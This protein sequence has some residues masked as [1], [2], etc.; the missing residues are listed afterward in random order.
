MSL[1]NPNKPVTEQR[2]SEFY[3]QILPF[4]GGM[5]DILT[6]KFSKGDLYSTDEKMIGRWIDGKPIYQK[7]FLF[8]SSVTIPSNS[9][10]NTN[11]P[12]GDIEQTLKCFCYKNDYGISF[13][14]YAELD[15]NVIELLQ[16]RGSEMGQVNGFVLQYT[17]TTDSSVEIGVDTDYSTEEKIVGT[18]IDGKPL[19]QKTIEVNITLSSDSWAGSVDVS[20]FNL[21]SIINAIGHSSALKG[22]LSIDTRVVSDT[23]SI[24]TSDLGGVVVNRLTLQYTKT[25]D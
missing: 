5:P 7:V 11:M 13:P 9:W 1:T 4:L 23:L 15:A 12:S 17:K 18:W 19:Y 21:D 3:Q 2:L 6:N 25:T 10:F 16:T 22:S 24:F 14:V 8:P 20:S